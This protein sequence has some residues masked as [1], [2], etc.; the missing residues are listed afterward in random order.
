VGAFGRVAGQIANDWASQRQT[1]QQTSEELANNQAQRGE[2]AQRIKSQM[3][4]DQLAQAAQSA[5]ERNDSL[6]NQVLQQNLKTAGWDT[7]RGQYEQDDH[8][9]WLFTIRNPYTKETRSFPAG[10]PSGVVEKE[11][12]DAAAMARRQEQDKAA[13]DRQREGELAKKLA[14]ATKFHNDMSLLQAKQA[15]LDK[16]V[17]LVND[18]KGMNAKQQWGYTHDPD[19]QQ[20]DVDTREKYAEV[21]QIDSIIVAGKNPLAMA[22]LGISPNKA[23]DDDDKANLMERKQD[24]VKQIEQNVMQQRM[25]RARYELPVPGDQPGAPSSGAPAAPS[26]PDPKN[27][28]PVR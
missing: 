26:Q 23:L 25:I 21:K 18:L 4:S 14:A 7:D 19:K 6:K 2:I 20:L 16:R 15:D 10:K 8:G 11:D 28:V 3:L 22:F 27:L 17:R 12:T 24:L 1:N 5:T 13:A 9:N